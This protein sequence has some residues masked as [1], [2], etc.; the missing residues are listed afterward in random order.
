MIVIDYREEGLGRLSSGDD[1]GEGFDLARVL[2]MEEQ[3]RLRTGDLIELSG[4]RLHDAF[5]IYRL[6]EK[7]TWA[8]IQHMW[9]NHQVKPFTFQHSEVDPPQDEI[10]LIPAMD[11]YGYGVPYVFA[12]R[13]SALLPD[14]AAYKYVDINFP[15]VARHQDNETIALVQR[16]LQARLKDPVYYDKDVGEERSVDPVRFPQQY[17]ACV[18]IHDGPEDNVTWTYRIH[19]NEKEIA[20]DLNDNAVIFFSRRILE[21]EEQYRQRSSS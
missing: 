20:R 2:T 1:N 15:L 12:T 8:Q 7:G 19:Y 11:E 21:A 10:I 16:H 6:P 18:N 13:P 4:N 9:S 3:I 5:Y 17:V 14:G